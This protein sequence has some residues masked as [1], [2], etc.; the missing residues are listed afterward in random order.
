VS[1]RFVGVWR[2]AY[3]GHYLWENLDWSTLDSKWQEPA[4]ERFRLARSTTSGAQRTWSGLWRSSIAA[5]FSNRGPF[6]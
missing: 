3:D 2:S 1:R 5:S 6:R 4:A